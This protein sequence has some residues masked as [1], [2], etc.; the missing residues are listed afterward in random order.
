MTMVEI[1]HIKSLLGNLMSR[2]INRLIA[3]IVEDDMVM[4]KKIKKS[5]LVELTKALM[6]DNLLELADDT[7][8][9]MYEEQF[10]TYLN[11][12]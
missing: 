8:V 10:E 9:T 3:E 5:E 6:R 11:V 12:R 2:M 4:V 7:I 1:W